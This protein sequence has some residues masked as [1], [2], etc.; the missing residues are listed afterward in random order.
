MSKELEALNKLFVLS[1]EYHQKLWC[2][3]LAPV[4]PEEREKFI[5]RIVKCL[6]NDAGELNDLYNYI[7]QTLARNEPMKV[8]NRAETEE[9]HY[10]VEE[11]GYIS[12]RHYLIT[13]TSGECPVCGE[14][15]DDRENIVPPIF[16]PHCG[17][18]L[19]WTK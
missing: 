18:R 7:K 4:Y 12:G 11:Q 6:P 3:K 10:E 15:M 8:A 17:Q 9:G 5:D 16:C 13:V 14:P 19:D 2:L 1:S